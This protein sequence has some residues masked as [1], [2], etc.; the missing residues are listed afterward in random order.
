M[1]QVASRDVARSKVRVQLLGS[2]P[3]LRLV[4]EA[5]EILAKDYKIASDAWSVTSYSRPRYRGA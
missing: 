1:Y 5:Q 3:I 4:L 2:G